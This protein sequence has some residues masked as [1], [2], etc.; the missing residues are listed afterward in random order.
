MPYRNWLHAADTAEAVMTI[1]EK[2]SI[3][4]IYN[5]AGGFEQRNIDTVESIVKSYF[6]EESIIPEDFIDFSISRPGQD[7]RYALDDSKLRSLGWEPNR[8]FSKEIEAIVEYYKYKF[9]W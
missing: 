1:I 9:I 2:G 8:V 4:E 6:K 7:I 3:G 5:V